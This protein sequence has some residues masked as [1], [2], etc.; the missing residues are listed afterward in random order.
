[1]QTIDPAPEAPEQT[2][3]E[4]RK[5]LHITLLILLGFF[6]LQLSNPSFLGQIT[7]NHLLKD[8][9]KLPAAMTSSFFLIVG[10]AWYCK[11]VA[12][13]LTDAFPLFG[14]RRR[15][16][17]L[18]SIAAAGACWVA[19]SF[20]PHE[21]QVLVGSVAVLNCFLVMCSTVLGGFL[22]EAGQRMRA[23]G[24]LTATRMFGTYTAMLIMGP[25]GGL[26][27][28]IGLRATAWASAAC[29]L[30]VFP[31][32]YVYLKEK[33]QK[34]VHLEAIHN[35]KQQL[36]AIVRS[37]TLWWALVFASLF[38]FAPGFTTP[39]YYYQKDHLGVDDQFV[40][41]LGMMKGAG[42]IVGAILY[43]FLARRFSLVKLLA[44]GIT[45][46]A[47]CALLY[48]LYSSPTRALAV[49]FTYGFGFA[50]AEVCLL[51]LCARSTPKGSEALG[52]ALIVSVTNLTTQGADVIGSVLVGA[53]W[54]FPDLVLLNAGTSLVVLILL[55]FLPRTLLGTRDA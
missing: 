30:M 42:L 1:M 20:M 21:Y 44:F 48:L 24:R 46:S 3:L 18:I 43:G 53:K 35:A 8:E 51:D 55:P 28:V 10:L 54:S 36:S 32:A 37:K 14:T 4:D 19:I 25:L 6:G 50:L 22:V 34:G 15:H 26:L 29:I 23:T 7:F 49:D 45:I 11:P 33:P 40:G 9:L 31:L 27:A 2:L 39:L 16:Y 13:I 38:Y 47:L 5:P 52:F 17:L 12:G 41:Y